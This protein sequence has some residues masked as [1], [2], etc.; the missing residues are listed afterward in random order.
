MTVLIICGFSVYFRTHRDPAVRQFS[1]NLLRRRYTAG[2]DVFS[3]L[4]LIWGVEV[5]SAPYVNVASWFYDIPAHL[6]V[7]FVAMGMYVGLFLFFVFVFI[8]CGVVYWQ[9]E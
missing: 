7:F 6:S 1:F 9:R 4:I 5:V 2:F 8:F 3:L